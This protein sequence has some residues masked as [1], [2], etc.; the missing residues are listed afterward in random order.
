MNGAEEHGQR[1]Q[2]RAQGRALGVLVPEAVVGRPREP[3]RTGHS[4]VPGETPDAGAGNADLSAKQAASRLRTG[5]QKSVA[6]AVAAAVVTWATWAP[7]GN[8]R[9]SAGLRRLVPGTLA[10]GRLKTLARET[11]TVG[12]ERGR[13][14][15]PGPVFGG[16]SGPVHSAAPGCVFRELTH[17]R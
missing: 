5:G 12:H 14:T 4:W 15:G 17:W 13:K 9:D 16:F 1:A 3:S 8:V 6:V 11:G 2:G 10:L 7:A